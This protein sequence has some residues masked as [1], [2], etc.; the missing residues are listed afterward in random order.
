M[1]QRWLSD[2]RWIVVRCAK[3]SAS[4]APA[5]QSES[6][7]SAARNR[8]RLLN[9]PIKEGLAV[10]GLT[11][12]PIIWPSGRQ[13][14]R[15]AGWFQMIKDPSSGYRP[16]PAPRWTPSVIYPQYARVIIISRSN[17]Y[18]WRLAS[19][20]SER[21]TDMTGQWRYLRLS[22]PNPLP[23]VWFS[24]YLGLHCHPTFYHIHD[25]A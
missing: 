11:D 6:E 16:P 18:R 21:H 9:L 4:I 25:E 13:G 5:S 23:S 3:K 20:W 14:A 7:F 19:H 22:E 24:T 8:R 12:L 10:P 15:M 17:Y 1:H 2:F